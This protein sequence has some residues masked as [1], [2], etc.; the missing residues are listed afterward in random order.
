MT[1]ARTLQWGPSAQ[2]PQSPAPY[3]G[4]NAGSLIALTITVWGL[5]SLA[6]LVYL[7]ELVHKD[8]VVLWRVGVRD[9]S[10]AGLS[11]IVA[12][13]LRVLHRL[14]LAA[15][16]GVSVVLAFLA[17]LAYSALGLVLIAP[18]FDAT[19]GQGNASEYLLQHMTSHY[20]VFLAYA[21]LFLLLDQHGEAAQSTSASNPNRRILERRV[22]SQLHTYEGLNTRWFWTFQAVF[23][24]LMF[25]FST[26]NAVNGGEPFSS[27][28]WR[29]AIVEMTGLATTTIVHF[30]LLKPTRFQPLHKRAAGAL[31]AALVM[32]MV[33]VTAIWAVY[34]QLFPVP[35]EYGQEG[36]RLTGLA[37]LLRAGPRWMFLNFPVFVGWTGFYL[38]LDAARRVRQQERQLYNSVVLAQ[39]AQLKMLRFQLNPHFLF[40]TLNAISTLILDKRPDDAEAML[41]RL[42]Q[43]LRFTLDAAPGDC[44]PL[45][46][47]IAAQKLYLEIER[48]RFAER[49]NVEI[50]VPR[51]IQDTLVPTLILQPLTE[52]A[53]KYAVAR[54][55][56][57][58][59][60]EIVG[61]R[62]PDGRLCLEVRDNGPSAGVSAP[63]KGAG[64]GLQNVRA[65]LAVLYG[66]AAELAAG[67]LPE[68]GF[69]AAMI[70]PIET[71]YDALNQMPADASPRM[72]N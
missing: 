17:N 60:I 51:D 45:S 71:D 42:S 54:S 27:N 37:L 63:S 30:A 50:K 47:E 4:L 18:L 24:T 31:L 7:F 2:Q 35:A 69:V 5:F 33:Y 13:V 14:G 44:C 49:L 29:I 20:W 39:E 16:L 23:W 53:V 72:E 21:G 65:R 9:L 52:N 25:I 3:A 38:A 36:D 68:G 66:D 19:V 55:Q 34:F 32:T 64:V 43:F 6:S 26:A 15:K 46:Q 8:P 58:V 11:L 12:M 70:L 22:A 56:S 10:G 57:A 28:W 40:N 62:L 59:K 48:A 1:D 41:G 61:E 67:P